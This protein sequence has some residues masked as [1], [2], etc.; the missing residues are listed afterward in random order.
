M[1]PLERQIKCVAREIG[2]R[3]RVYPRWVAQGKMS[4]KVADE[5][6][7]AMRAVLASLQQLAPRGADPATS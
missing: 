4:Q 7:E 1:I 5:E 2:M 3:E 6:I